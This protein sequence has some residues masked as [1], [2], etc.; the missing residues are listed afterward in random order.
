MSL[1]LRCTSVALPGN[2]ASHRVSER[3]GSRLVDRS[4][5]IVAGTPRP[6]DVYEMT[7]GTWRAQRH[8]E[9]RIVVE[10]E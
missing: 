2:V 8:P 3:V 7:V 9:A 6:I 4:E 5:P 10:P 1:V